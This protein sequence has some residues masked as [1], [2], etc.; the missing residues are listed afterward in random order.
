M[1]TFASIL[2]GGD[3]GEDPFMPGKSA[4]SEIILRLKGLEGLEIMPPTGKL[5]DKLIAMVEKWIDEGAKFDPVD[6]RV[7]LKT[8]AAKG[9]ANSLDH[10]ELVEWRKGASEDTWRL[11]LASVKPTEAALENFLVLGTGSE[12]RLQKIGKVAEKLADGVAKIL[13]AP[14]D[15]PFVKGRTTLFV[16]AKR[17]DF[18]EFGRMVERRTF[19]KSLVSSW[20]SDTAIAHVVLKCGIN[21]VAADYE[22]SLARDIASVHVA[23]W[24]ASVPRCGQQYGD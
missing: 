16:V 9:L 22:V 14:K 12:T 19:A 18:A 4:T 23:N 10:K 13:G 2:R 1:A 3:S 8:V 21:D 7:P 11:A 5:D 6:L 20:Q 15:Q 24:N 17:Y